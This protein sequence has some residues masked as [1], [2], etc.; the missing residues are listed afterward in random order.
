MSIPELPQPLESA[1]DYV[2]AI[3]DLD[4]KINVIESFLGKLRRIRGR[5]MRELETLQ[6]K[7]REVRSK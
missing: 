7:R 2:K 6:E 1:E 5:Y 4:R 3:E